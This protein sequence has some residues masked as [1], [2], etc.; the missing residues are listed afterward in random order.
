MTRINKTM[1]IDQLASEYSGTTMTK[2]ALNRM[3]Q[4]L[5]EYITDQVAEGN[6]VS[7]FGLGTF[8]RGFRAAREARNPQ[9][10]GEI[11][12]DAKFAPKFKPSSDFKRAVAE[13]GKDEAA[14]RQ[15]EIDE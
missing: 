1:L 11:H 2:T 12:V 7:V 14:E 3:Y 13:R 15:A 6:E 5:V 9:T 8:K 10:G 4:S